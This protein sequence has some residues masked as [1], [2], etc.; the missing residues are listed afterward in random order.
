MQELGFVTKEQQA[1]ANKEKVAFAAQ[2][3]SSISAPHFVFYILDYL[4]TKYGESALK[5]GITVTTTL[6]ADLQAHGESIIASYSENNLKNFN[7]SN[8][9]MIALDP[10]TGQILA[11]VGSKDFFSTDIDGQ[12]NATLA[13]RQPGST[14]KPFV[15]ALALMRGY[16]RNTVVFDVPTQFSTSCQP[17]EVTNSEPPCYAPQ[18]FDELSRGPM[19]FETALAQSINIPA[20]KV[21]YLVGIRN[22]VALAEVSPRSVTP[23]SMV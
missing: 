13:L 2:G 3:G 12:Y 19:T 23:T 22:A 21:L 7:A 1:F 4:R 9:S 17:T 16:T 5:T 15:Y 6:D 20:I 14:F 10:A 11:M 8:E 18:N